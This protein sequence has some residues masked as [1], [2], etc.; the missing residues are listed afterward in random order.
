DENRYFDVFVEYGKAA[1]AEEFICLVA[2]DS[3]TERLKNL[4]FDYRLGKRYL[5]A[6]V[7]GQ[8]L[9]T[10]NET[11]AQR[12]FGVPGVHAYTKDAF[13]RTI[14]NGELKRGPRISTLGSILAISKMTLDL[15]GKSSSFS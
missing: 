2:D 11:N 13:H 5:Y 12:L 6:E 4:P 1:S 15:E 9:F 3:G 10:D 7:N 14:V 8:P